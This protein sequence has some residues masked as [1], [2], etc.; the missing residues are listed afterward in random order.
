[1]GRPDPGSLALLV[2][3]RIL[4]TAT[5]TSSWISVLKK[6]NIANLLIWQKNWNSCLAV[7]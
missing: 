1:M 5:S 4:L 3:E 7:Q 6:G 2:G